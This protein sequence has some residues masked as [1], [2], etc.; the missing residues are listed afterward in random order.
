MDFM[1]TPIGRVSFAFV[2][3]SGD[4]KEPGKY[5]MTLML[6]KNAQAIAHLGMTDAASKKY[7]ED[8]LAFIRVLTSDVTE[9]AKSKWKDK[10]KSKRWNPII[11]GDTKTDS[12]KANE[13]FWLLRMKTKYQPKIVNRSGE[14]II[15]GNTDP[16]N[17]F[18]SG[19]WARCVI[20]AYTYNMGGNEGV[21][22][23]LGNK[24]QKAWNDEVFKFTPEVEFTG[25]IT[26]LDIDESDFAVTD[27]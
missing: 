19:C 10:F 21:S 16:K 24:I 23:G 5:K 15:D 1:Q 8:V 11:D 9:M 4:P 12:F 18:Y 2:H 26:S 20:S 14:P 25:E 27:I 3:G 22:L 13:N 7:L 6:P 17:G